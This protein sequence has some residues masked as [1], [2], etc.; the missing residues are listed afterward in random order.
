MDGSDVSFVVIAFN[1]QDHISSCVDAIF[2]QRDVVPHEV[3]VVDDASTDQTAAVVTAKAAEH[4]NLRL[5]R[6]PQNRGRGAARRTGQDAATTRY[7]AFVDSDIWIPQDWLKHALDS[8]SD[9]DVIS[10]VAVPDGDCAV[11][12]RIF[13]PIPKGRPPTWALTGSNVIFRKDALDKVGWPAGSRLTED[14]RLARALEAAGFRVKT[15]PDLK[16]EHHEAKSYR[17]TLAFMW[18]MGF[19][20]TELVRDLRLVRLPDVAWLG[21]LAS[22]LAAIG[23]AAAGVVPWWVV[24]AWL[25]ILTASIDAVWMAQRFFVSRSPLR[26]CAAWAGNFPMIATY[27]VARSF[28]A[29]RLLRSR[30]TAEH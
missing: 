1:E 14:N 6:H 25:A 10:G 24:P 30:E 27:L 22:S 29:P 19:N 23:L 15:V 12:W 5:V 9:Y 16:A 28:Y 2:A 21:W 18:E 7:V 4:P 26:W 8:L 11:I 17:K 13:R 20:S 3:I